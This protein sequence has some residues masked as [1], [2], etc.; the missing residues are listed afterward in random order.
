MNFKHLPKQSE[1]SFLAYRLMNTKWRPFQR[2][3]FV[4][5]LWE[6]ERVLIRSVKHYDIMKLL[7]RSKFVLN[8]VSSGAIVVISLSILC[9]RINCHLPRSKFTYADTF[10]TNLIVY[11]FNWWILF[12]LEPVIILKCVLSP[13]RNIL[14][15]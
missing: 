5:L 9:P 13:E 14:Y 2:K 11:L 1:H 3:N 8:F 6:M 12:S 7:T 4:F 10:T 15:F